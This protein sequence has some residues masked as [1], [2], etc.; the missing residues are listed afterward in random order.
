[1][2]CR[3]SF[4]TYPRVLPTVLLLSLSS[5]SFGALLQSTDDVATQ[6]ASTQYDYIVVGAGAAGGV[7]ANRLTE[8][9][10]T[11]V[12]LI[13]AGSRYVLKVCMISKENRC[14]DIPSSDYNNTNIQ[15]PWLAPV[16][17][18]SQFVSIG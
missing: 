17:T 18:H 4:A 3:L 10:T 14:L 9:E 5:L 16:L 11:K 6:L 8:D 13:E 2:T 1:M 7:L 12:L 15:I